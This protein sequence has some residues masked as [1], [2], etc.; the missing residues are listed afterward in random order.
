MGVGTAADGRG[1]GDGSRDGSWDSGP[2]GGGTVA[3]VA[4]AGG[5]GSS[6]DDSDFGSGGRGGVGED[7]RRPVRCGAT[8]VSA[9]DALEA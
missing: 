1:D 9:S 8:F 7:R 5:L 4:E 6:A 2:F 3:A